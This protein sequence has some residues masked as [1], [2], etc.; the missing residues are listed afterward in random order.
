MP[1]EE[2]GDVSEDPRDDQ[3]PSSSVD[4][5]SFD[6]FFIYRF[7]MPR[8]PGCAL[9][10]QL[11]ESV[12]HNRDATTGV[13]QDKPTDR[14]LDYQGVQKLVRTAGYR[15]EACI[16]VYGKEVQ[17]TDRRPSTILANVTF[18]VTPAVLVGNNT[19]G[20]LHVAEE[21][22]IAHD[23]ARLSCG[24]EELNFPPSWY[25]EPLRKSEAKKQAYME[26]L[27]FCGA[28]SEDASIFRWKGSPR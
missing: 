15:A 26:C 3:V 10:L 7:C 12:F 21:A 17:F 4:Q 24:L 18:Y 9:S 16:R 14:T 27:L 28:F 22:A 13:L 8:V 20:D 1:R 6:R 25:P 5:A 23:L 2:R 19:F 11:L